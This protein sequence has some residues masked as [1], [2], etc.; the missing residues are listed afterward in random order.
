MDCE[1]T[2]MIELALL[3]GLCGGGGGAGQ[4]GGGG[5]CQQVL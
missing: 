5:H 3:A 4:G 2:N 1:V